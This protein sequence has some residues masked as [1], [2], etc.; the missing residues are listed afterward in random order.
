M[1]KMP[2]NTEGK[3]FITKAGY[4]IP[5]CGG[6]RGQIE[7]CPG[8]NGEG[9]NANEFGSG[10]Y[11]HSDGTIHLAEPWN[12]DLEIV[13]EY[14]YAMNL[15]EGYNWKGGF[16]KLERVKLG[17][18]YLTIENEALKN[19]IEQVEIVNTDTIGRKR[20]ILEKIPTP[21]GVELKDGW[22]ITQS[23]FAVEIRKTGSVFSGTING[24][25]YT[26]NSDGSN[27]NAIYENIIG[28]CPRELIPTLPSGY[29]WVGGHPKFVRPEVGDVFLNVLKD[30]ETRRNNC[31][32]LFEYGAAGTRRI[33][34]KKLTPET[35]SL[36]AG[37]IYLTKGGWLVRINSVGGTLA[38]LDLRTSPGLTSL[39]ALPASCIP[40]ASKNE[41]WVLCS[42]IG[43]KPDDVDISDELEITSE[44]TDKLNPEFP[45]PPKGYKWKH[46]FPKL[47]EVGDNEYYIN[48]YS[49]TNQNTSLCLNSDKVWLCLVP[50]PTPESVEKLRNILTS[51][52]N[53]GTLDL[54]ISNEAVEEIKNWN[55]PSDIITSNTQIGTMDLY[56][57]P[58]QGQFGEEWRD[59]SNLW[60][61][62]TDHNLT[63]TKDARWDVLNSVFNK[64]K[65]KEMKKETAIAASKA[66]GSFAW[67][68]VNYLFLETATEIGQRI[69]R[70][71][72]YA[73]FFGTLV[74]GIGFWVA[75]E[76]TTAIIK[77]CLPK[78]SISIDAPE[79]VR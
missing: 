50:E 62:S 8:V 21:T 69:G 56:W 39:S 73:V 60:T 75:P 78:V 65:E 43:D 49:I 72:R 22:Y 47:T 61:N 13:G 20:I 19:T 68:T 51:N 36:E 76:K 53:G 67:K 48:E 29:E 54:L 33:L 40:R 70:S 16:P 63:F 3:I 52:N 15:P 41:G 10:W 71:I 35:R 42:Q 25:S 64:E 27:T 58:K 57:K 77:S 17:D 44:Y 46:G 30:P 74:T 37:K 5:F 28:E 79:I 18:H 9:H 14:G 6:S 55:K 11:W 26:W 32:D 66:V 2:A 45:D 12:K 34:I 4:V 1:Y 7:Y 31:I 23:G 24:W 59:S 38:Y